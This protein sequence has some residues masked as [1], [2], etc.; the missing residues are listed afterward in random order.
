MF[1]WRY[2]EAAARLV[3]PS[4]SVPHRV[5]WFSPWTVL[6]LHRP[7]SSMRD[8]NFLCLPISLTSGRGIGRVVPPVNE[9]DSVNTRKLKKGT[10]QKNCPLQFFQA[11]HSPI[12]SSFRKKSS[13]TV[14]TTSS[15]NAV[16]IHSS[17]P[18][19]PSPD[20]FIIDVWLLLLVRLPSFCALIPSNS[21]SHFLRGHFNQFVGNYLS[22]WPLEIR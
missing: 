1:S 12:I 7:I 6:S 9:I 17:H 20:C 19:S 8:S 4:Q 21:P 10:V 15:F 2:P 13:S 3:P 18:H 16:R 22:S 5:S 11:F 14:K